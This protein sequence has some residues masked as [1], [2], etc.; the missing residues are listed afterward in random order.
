MPPPGSNLYPIGQ[1]ANRKNCQKRQFVYIVWYGPLHSSNKQSQSATNLAVKKCLKIL[2]CLVPPDMLPQIIS[3]T[4][5]P[6]N[7]QMLKKY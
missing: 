7:E 1:N 5:F 6:C 3:V 4:N 2:A